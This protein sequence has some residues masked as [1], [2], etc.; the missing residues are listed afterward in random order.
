FHPASVADY[1]DAVSN[2][3]KAAAQ[4]KEQQARAARAIP[5]GVEVGPIVLTVQGLENTRQA[6]HQPIYWLGPKQGYR[7]DLER[8]PSN[9]A[10]VTY[11]PPGVAASSN[12]TRYVVIGS[13][14]LRN[15]EAA[16]RKTANQSGND[17]INLP[18][19][20]IA[21]PGKVHPHSVYVAYPTLDTEIEVYSPQLGEARTLV[22][23]GTL[24]PVG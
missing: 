23:S 16:L 19:G 20:G 10:Y 22:L 24:R 8:T 5:A 2:V 12:R 17:I 21:V 7:Y 13:Y 11:L 3:Q 6:L 1:N 9:D 4:A 15:P 18:G 14:P